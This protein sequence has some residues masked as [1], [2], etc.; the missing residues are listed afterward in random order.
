MPIT[1]YAYAVLVTSTEHV[2]LAL[3]QL[4]LAPFDFMRLETAYWM[5][6][7]MPL[8]SG[9]FSFLSA[10]ASICRIR[11]LVTERL[12]PTCSSVQA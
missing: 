4:G 7:N 1:R 8:T 5:A 3:A 10:F 6:A 12:C 9:V 2:I 11:S